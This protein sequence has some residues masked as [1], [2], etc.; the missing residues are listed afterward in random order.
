MP[1]S[2]ELTV[3]VEPDT[4]SVCLFVP[5]TK[6]NGRKAETALGEWEE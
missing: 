2:I 6:E 5:G 1:P 3:L 4:F